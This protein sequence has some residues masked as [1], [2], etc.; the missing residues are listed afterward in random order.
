MEC[1]LIQNLE[2]KGDF[3]FIEYEKQQ[4]GQEALR[5]V[6]NVCM[7]EIY[8]VIKWMLFFVCFLPISHLPT[9]MTACHLIS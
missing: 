5:F 3:A 7:R 4:S 9:A 1:G 6:S 8:A 2:F